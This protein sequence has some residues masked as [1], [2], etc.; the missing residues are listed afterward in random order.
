MPKGF[1]AELFAGFANEPGIGRADKRALTT[2]RSPFRECPRG[3][4]AVSGNQGS[5]DQAALSMTKTWP[6]SMNGCQ[7]PMAV[8]AAEMRNVDH[9]QRVRGFDSDARATGSQ[10]RKCLR[11]AAQASGHFS[12]RKVQIETVAAAQLR[13]QIFQNGLSDWA[14]GAEPALATCGEIGIGR[15]NGDADQPAAPAAAAWPAPASLAAPALPPALCIVI[16]SS[17]LRGTSALSG[18]PA[19][20]RPGPERRQ[21]ARRWR[22]FRRRVRL[23]ARRAGLRPRPGLGRGN[24]VGFLAVEF[25]DSLDEGLVPGLLIGIVGRCQGLGACLPAGRPRRRGSCVLDLGTWLKT[26]LRS[27]TSTLGGRLVSSK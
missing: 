11:V 22:Q 8:L 1:V 12:P 25:G 18:L 15:G 5:G 10:S 7:Q 17:R 24:L 23:P 4:D 9:R 20:N 14:A 6:P 21:P 27:Q 19:E 26:Y 3:A 16:R 13:L 2:I